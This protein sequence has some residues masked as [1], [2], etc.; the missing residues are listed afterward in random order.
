MYSQ[1]FV[2]REELL[3]YTNP[4]IKVVLFN[5]RDEP[6]Q[7]IQDLKGSNP[8]SDD[9]VDQG[10]E[11]ISF[12]MP[13]LILLV[14]VQGNEE[15]ISGLKEISQTHFSNVMFLFCLVM[16]DNAN[17]VDELDNVLIGFWQWISDN[18]QNASNGFAPKK[19][20]RDLDVQK[21]SNQRIRPRQRK[22]VVSKQF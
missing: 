3:A 21:P 6:T 13:T 15:T 14:C 10:R 4:H 1:T 20:G 8:R 17:I 12:Q 19:R 22:V 9:S 18:R 16:H 7:L 11:S 2:V 5:Q